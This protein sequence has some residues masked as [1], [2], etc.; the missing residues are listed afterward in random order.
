MKILVFCFAIVTSSVW[1]SSVSLGVTI[2][3]K[4]RG[5]APVILETPTAI[6]G[7][8]EIRTETYLISPE[9]L[10]KRYVPPITETKIIDNKAYI[11]TIREGYYEDVLVPAQYGVRTYQV[12]VPDNPV[13][14][15]Y[16]K[17]VYRWYEPSFNFSF[18]YSHGHG[19]SKH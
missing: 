15:I 19:H 7:H 18:G 5:T 17:P 13:T 16:Q 8:Y 9:R 3:P 6:S 10:E 11:F 1:A 4:P 14:Y 2:A 12:W